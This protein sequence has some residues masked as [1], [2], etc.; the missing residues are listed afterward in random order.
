MSLY[1]PIYYTAYM[2]D[3]RPVKRRREKSM[4]QHILTGGKRHD[5][6]RFFAACPSHIFIFMVN[7]FQ[8][9]PPRR[10]AYGGAA[11]YHNNICEGESIHG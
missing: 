4:K 9:Q 11:S 3:A 5:K 8:I 2:G 7:C 10:H 6:P 1:K